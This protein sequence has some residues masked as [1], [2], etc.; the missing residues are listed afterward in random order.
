MLPTQMHLCRLDLAMLPQV[1]KSGP[2]F[3]FCGDRLQG[4][5]AGE[6]VVRLIGEGFL[7]H[8]GLPGKNFSIGMPEGSRVFH[9]QTVHASDETCSGFRWVDEPVMGG[10]IRADVAR[11]EN[12]H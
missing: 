5:F 8:G 12:G 1:R 10:H 3:A 9:G 11:M 6:Q 7:W 2:C 4:E